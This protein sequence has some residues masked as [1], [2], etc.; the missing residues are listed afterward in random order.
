MPAPN[1]LPPPAREQ[2]HRVKRAVLRFP[3]PPAWQ[4]IVP[5]SGCRLLASRQSKTRKWQ[6]SSLCA[7]SNG[8]YQSQAA[9]LCPG[10][11]FNIQH[12]TPKHPTPK[13]KCRKHIDHLAT[14]ESQSSVQTPPLKLIP[15]GGGFQ[16]NNPTD[17]NFIEGLHQGLTLQESSRAVFKLPHHCQPNT[18]HPTLKHPNTQRPNTQR[19]NTQRPTLSGQPGRPPSDQH[20]HNP[21]PQLSN[22][23][24]KQR[25]PW[26]PQAISRTAIPLPSPTTDAIPEKCARISGWCGREDV[27]NQ[28]LSLVLVLREPYA[29]R[30]GPIASKPT[31]DRFDV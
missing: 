24:L 21:N 22:G 1:G 2:S 6:G 3:P 17:C 15:E 11:I 20:H 26:W 14:Q 13:N 27:R 8:R 4:C 5:A 7:H 31:G 18:Q 12:P 28:K 10:T 23:A 30:K 29:K 25:K 19:P 16:D 9:F